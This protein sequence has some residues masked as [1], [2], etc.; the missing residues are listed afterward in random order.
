VATV[1]SSAQTA[2]N[3]LRMAATTKVTDHIFVV[4][5]EPAGEKIGYSPNNNHIYTIERKKTVNKSADG[6]LI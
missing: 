5:C 2:A 6:S 1:K 3:T 4:S